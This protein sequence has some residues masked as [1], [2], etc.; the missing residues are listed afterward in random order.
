MYGN[1]GSR[2]TNSYSRF[3]KKKSEDEM[4]SIALQEAIRWT[5]KLMDREFRGRGDKEYL[6]RYRLAESSGVPE[7]YLYRLQYK[8]KAMKDV[9]GEY[10]RRLR[11]YYER[12]CEVNEAAADRYQ[13]ERQELTNATTSKKPASAGVAIH[14][15]RSGAVDQAEA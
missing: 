8:S 14:A 10:Y 4:T 2:R 5:G 11:L 1:Y 12:V 9:A 3:G 7:S 13:A 15:P 6:V